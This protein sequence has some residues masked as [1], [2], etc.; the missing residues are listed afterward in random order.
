[1]S[2]LCRVKAEFPSTSGFAREPDRAASL[3]RTWLRRELLDRLLAVSE[4]H[5]RQV[6]TEYLQHYNAA[7]PHRSPS[8][9]S[10]PPKPDPA[11]PLRSTSPSIG[12]A[13]NR[14][15]E[16]SSAS[17]ASPPYRPALL[18]GIKITARIMFRQIRAQVR[19]ALVIFAGENV[20]GTGLRDAHHSS[21]AARS[22]AG[23]VI[24][25][26]SARVS[27]GIQETG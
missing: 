8:P 24:A 22:A 16:A 23:A 7:R 6:L 26:Q 3:P 1:V 2:F 19:V 9:S 12:S 14:Y 18:R 25:H 11:G 17:T 13:A 21:S 20:M 10:I 4:G 5:L 15:S 27:C